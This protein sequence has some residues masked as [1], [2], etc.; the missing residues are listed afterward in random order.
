[1]KAY[2][3]GDYVTFI[4]LGAGNVPSWNNHGPWF[5]AGE[6]SGGTSTVFDGCIDDVRIENTVRTQAYLKQLYHNALGLFDSYSGITGDTGPTGPAGPTGATGPAGP[7]GA[8]G[9]TGAT[10][11][12]G[13]TGPAGP[14][15]APGPTGATG[16]I[17][18][19]MSEAQHA[20]LRQL[21]HFIDEGPAEEFAS[22]AY[23]EVIGT[24]NPTSI[25]WYDSNGVGKKKIVEKLI[26]WSGP[27][28]ATII[29][30][31]YDTFES[32]AAT[33][34]DTIKYSGLFE[35][36]RLRA[37][38]IVIP[39][40]ATS[41]SEAQ[42]AA[43]RQ[44]IHFIDQGPAEEFTSG[45]YKEVTGGAFPTSIIWY[46]SNGVGKKKIVEKLITWVGTIASTI[47][48]K[49]YDPSETLLATVTDTIT[50]SGP[51]ESNRL[52]AIT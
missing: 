31:I 25:I 52:R 45:A 27:V 7:T 4:N 5:I 36:S 41:F 20:S 49:V 40:P 8:S 19:G 44:L 33:V 21:I 9:A 29:W 14:T 1:M 42:H 26:T 6:I 18:A 46:D 37:I 28:P 38:T 30:N 11:A 15:G 24:I 43:L 35:A 13:A 51:F 16:P 47:V 10:G 23:K 3:N 50:Y 32:L 34:V 39:I 48:W 17:G 12:S 2:L 22:G